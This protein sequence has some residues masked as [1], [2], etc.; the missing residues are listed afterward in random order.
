M[1]VP[2]KALPRHSYAHHCHYC[3]IHIIAP[4]SL[5]PATPKRC[6]SSLCPSCTV[7]NSAIAGLCNAKPLLIVAVLCRRHAPLCHRYTQLCRC[8][9]VLCRCIILSEC[10][11]KKWVRFTSML[12]IVLTSRGEAAMLEHEYALKN[13]AKQQAQEERERVR[14]RSLQRVEQ[15]NANRLSWI[16]VLAPMLVD[17]V[18]GLLNHL[19]H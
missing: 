13:K 16:Q 10:H 5:R 4:A 1:P 7:L 18:R 3:A 12:N 11:R 2:R 14:S 8:S 17:A 6:I 15:A 9:A 19:I